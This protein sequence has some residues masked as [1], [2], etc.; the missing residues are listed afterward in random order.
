[1]ITIVCVYNNE[2]ML[3]DVLLKSLKHQTTQFELITLD[4]RN[5]RFKSAAEALNYGGSKA[6]GEYIMY[7]HQDMWFGN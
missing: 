2:K 1:M 4:N 6:A 3:H 7:A 5:H